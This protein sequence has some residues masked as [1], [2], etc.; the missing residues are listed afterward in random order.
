MRG[1]KCF[2]VHDMDIKYCLP[3]VCDFDVRCLSA[4]HE[5]HKKERCIRP[6]SLNI[7]NDSLKASSSEGDGNH[8]AQRTS[9]KVCVDRECNICHQSNVQ[10]HSVMKFAEDEKFFKHVSLKHKQRLLGS[11]RGRIVLYG[12]ETWSHT[13]RGTYSEGVPGY[14]AE[15][16]IWT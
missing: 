6:C 4:T 7:R 16:D 2:C 10:R 12:C 3:E 13:E 5:V 11:V 15:E 14:G 1:H 9:N 8:P